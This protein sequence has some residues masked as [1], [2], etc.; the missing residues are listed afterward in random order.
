[1]VQD[2]QKVPS[3]WP[4]AMLFI[5][6]II[7][8]ATIVLFAVHNRK[9]LLLKE[10]QKELS[11]ISEIKSGQIVQWRIDRLGSADFLKENIL[12]ARKLEDYI[13]KPSNSALKED[14]LISFRSL[15]KNFDYRNILLLD[16]TGKVILSFPGQ[17]SLISDHLRP[18]IPGILLERKVKLTDIHVASLVSFVHMDLIVPIMKNENAP[19]DGLLILRLD[20][21]EF[22]YPLISSWPASGKT[23]ESFLIRQDKDNVVFLSDLPYMSGNQILTRRSVSEPLSP[24]AMAVRGVKSASDAIDYKGHH[25]VASMNKIPDTDWYLIAKID[26][27]E[28]LAPL[29]GQIT[30]LMMILFLLILAS[31]LIIRFFIWNQRVRF[32][33]ERHEYEQDRFAIMKQ[34]EETLK[35]SEE[36][37]RKLFED[38]PFSMVMADQKLRILKAN[39][40]F[41]MMTGYEEGELRDSTFRKFT[42]SEQAEKDEENIKMLI[43]GETAVYQTEKPY[44]RKDGTIIWG[45]T[46]ISTIRD[47]KGEIRFFLAMIEDITSKREASEEL[48]K[49]FSLLKA[50]IE[51]TA[52][53][54]LVINS[55]GKVVLYN[56]K[57]VEMW[58]IPEEIMKTGEDKVLLDYVR[59]QLKDPEKFIQVVENLYSYN[60]EITYDSLEFADGRHFERYSQPQ[61]INGKSVGR[62]WSFRDVTERKKAENDLVEAKEKAEESDRLKTAFLHNV[63]HEIRTPM[64]AIIGFTTLLNEKGTTE[65]EKQQFTGIITQSSNQLLSII[66]DIVDIANIESGQ[67]KVNFSR[68]NLNS[69]MKGLLEQFSYRK[70]NISIGLHL[71]LPDDQSYLVTDET[72]MIQVLSNLINNALKFTQEGRIDFGY[73]VQNEYIEFY[74]SD[75]GIGIP[76]EHQSKIFKRFYQVDFGGSRQYGGTGLGLSICEA[77]VILLGGEIHVASEPGKGSKFVFTLPYKSL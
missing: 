37:F 25:V 41:C 68:I 31:G 9:E 6:I 46:T 34:A 75:T 70:N 16:T 60:H 35:E 55:F 22:L 15:I 56:R 21:E 48:E 71:D 11:T 57:F 39:R 40:S 29:K 38:S 10:K 44:I 4:L 5:A 42:P 7:I 58:R 32:Y 69:C 2:K 24:C 66:N 14:I 18:L 13:N 62:V 19:V 47:N 45:M 67:V 3:S 36:R 51:S 43:S 77:Y 28:V 59:K 30:M 73:Q 8:S 53:G 17:D 52:D 61:I 49:S 72:K 50:T 27:E 12:F 63:S 65:Q 26:R 20:P 64:N 74:V 23:A 54:I 76:V 1:M 33:R